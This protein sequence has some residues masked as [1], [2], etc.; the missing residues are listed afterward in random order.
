M[1]NLKT[2]VLMQLKDKLDLSFTKSTRSTIIK[3]VTSII[4][5]AAVTAVFY[6]LFFVCNMLAIFRP[7]GVIPDSVVNVLF[8]LIQLMSVI[9]CTVGLTQALYMT[10]DN[11]VLLTLPVGSAT[12]F[13]S[14][15]VLYYIF[16]LKKNVTFTLPLFLAYGIINSAVWYYFVWMLICFVFISMIPVAIG[17]I[18]SIPALFIATFVKQIKWLQLVLIAAGS[19][20]VIWGV[21]ELI[22]VIPENIDINGTWGTIFLAIQNFLGEFSKIFYPY[23]CL[24]LMTVGGT[25]RISSK[26]FMGD[27]FIYL[28]VLLAFLSA[29]L[30]LAFLL[31]KPLFI[32]MAARQFEFEK[33]ATAPQK[34]RVHNAKLSPFFETV[35]MNIRSG[36]YV[37]SLIVQL[38]LPAIAILL[39]NRLYLSMNTNYS[40]HIMTKAFNFLVMLVITVSFNNQ[41]ATVYSKE[42]GARNIIK[43]RPQNPAYTLV[44]RI[45]LRM[46]VILISTL[47]V[48]ATFLSVSNAESGEIVLMGIITLLVSESHLLW[49]AESDIMHSCADQFATVGV[50]FDSPNERNATIIGFLL[51]AAFAFMYY[52]ISDR[53]TQSALIKELF[54][55]VAFA[56]ARVYLFFTRTKLYFAEN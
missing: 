38:V 48:T 5:L 9:T 16:E 54:A 12:V 50:Q 56:A 2:L 34:N 39:L 7:T 47:A 43:T 13:F 25:L 8:T 53:G 18:L 6:L 3:V 20:L 4:K 17:A 42:G 46:A 10:A 41:Y 21:V 24:T 44:G 51:A 14:K 1:N 33:N 52:F 26:L 55:A 40:G 31:S 19:G 15:L 30:G 11:K 27:T 32:K 36:R 49:C 45:G 22:G 28:A 37:V 29:L 35:T 23:Y